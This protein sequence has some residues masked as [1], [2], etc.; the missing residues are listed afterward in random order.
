MFMTTRR[1]AAPIEG[2]WQLACHPSALPNIPDTIQEDTKRF[3]VQVYVQP[4]ITEFI[5][6]A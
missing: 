1:Q 2:G 6:R 5:P 3:T 4:G